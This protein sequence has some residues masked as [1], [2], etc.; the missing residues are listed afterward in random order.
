[1]RILF[2]NHSSKIGGAET[3]LLNILRFAPT[4]GFTPVAVL[5][6]SDGPLKSCVNDLGLK[7]GIIDYHAFRWRN[8]LKYA[9]TITQL[10]TWI[11]QTHPDVIHLN[12]QW[13]VSHIVQV[14]ILTK[15]PVVCHTRNYLDETFVRWQQRWLTNAQAII[16]ESQAVEQRAIDL[17]LPQENLH[18]IYN[19]ID[20]ERFLRDESTK[21]VKI[22]KDQQGCGPIIGFSG[23]IVP[24]KGPEDLIR[25]IPLI[26]EAIP[27]VEVH[28][29]GTDQDNG[30]FIE[31]LKAIA[32]Q[33]GVEQHVQFLGFRHDTEN[34][35]KN[36]NILA[37]PSRQAMPEGLPL[38]ALEGLAAGCLVVATPNSGLP[39]V[40]QHGQT[41]FLVASDN[42]DLLA[43][44]LK[45]AMSMSDID[46]R[47]I[48]QAGR[49]L[50]NDRFRISYQI[51]KLK[52]LYSSIAVN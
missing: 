47:N 50:L 34:V 25:S 4:G 13:L 45:R 28:F 52:Q 31:H 6:P 9:K 10:I 18:L 32:S 27:T 16:V 46:T 26:L 41:G 14:G 29:L 43:Q 49:K 7:V 8:P 51:D 17:G 42:P 23:R 1:M 11:R 37:I 3:N 19:G 40:I 12:H 24:E 30:L 48:Q 39:E 5:L 36:F 21:T 33:L 15:T 22:T 38:T 2:V 44:A 20:H 35:L